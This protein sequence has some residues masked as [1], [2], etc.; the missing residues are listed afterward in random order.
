MVAHK[1]AGYHRHWIND[2]GSRIEE[3][4]DKGYDFVFT[5]DASI[6]NDDLGTRKSL[7]VS[8]NGPPVTAYLME[9]PEEKFL[10]DRQAKERAIQNTENQI[11]AASDGI[12]SERDSSGQ[13]VAYNPARSG[14]HL[15]D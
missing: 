1:R 15:L 8:K 13:S 4:L 3:M 14:N 5:K 6:N 7:Q 2:S 11:R 12:G 10:E 9:I